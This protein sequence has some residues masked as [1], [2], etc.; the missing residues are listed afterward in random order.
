MKFLVLSSNK[1]LIESVKQ[2][3]KHIHAID[4]IATFL[5]TD[6][7]SNTYEI[8]SI[9]KDWIEE[10]FEN[11]IS[12]M[13][14]VVAF[15][16]LPISLLSDF[17]PVLNSPGSL[18]STL[19]LAFPE[20]YW[21]FVL[22]M[23][24]NEDHYEY[25]SQNLFNY[26]HVLFNGNHFNLQNMIENVLYGYTPLFDP[27]GFRY[28]IIKN[29]LEH[30]K[31]TGEG[32]LSERP[33]FYKREKKALVVDEEIPYSYLHAYIAYKTGHRT[34]AVSTKK[35]LDKIKTIHEQAKKEKFH[36]SFEDICLSF[37]DENVPPELEKREAPKKDKKSK[38]GYS[39]FKS[40]ANRV[41]VTIGEPPGVKQ[42]N[43]AYR[44]QLKAQGKLKFYKILYKPYS[45]I[46]NLIKAA[47]L[48]SRKKELRK[49]DYNSS[50]G[51]SAPGRMGMIAVLLINRGIKILTS[52]VSAIDAVHAATLA[53]QA[54]EILGGRT[55]TESIQAVSLKHQAEVL[56]ECIFYG[57]EHNFDI[58]S[59][60]EE[61][62]NELQIIG[63]WF[64]R[65][66]R[67]IMIYNSEL[68]I[69]NEV[70]RIFRK[71]SQFDEEQQ[72]LDKVRG[73]NRKI[74]RGKHKIWGTITWPFRC[75][76]EYLMGSLNRFLAA[77]VIWPSLFTLI[78]Y[79]L[80]P[81]N[82]KSFKDALMYS[83]NSFFA[84]Q[85]TPIDML[86]NYPLSSILS[87]TAIILGFFHLGIFIS[88][89]YTIVSRR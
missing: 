3:L 84:L 12:K 10:L 74:Y 16:D 83:I 11:K 57:V 5:V 14:E 41:F 33:F 76:F 51:H 27:T 45:G 22:P 34:L 87:I 68:N 24:T 62:E 20:I 75:Y 19:Y 42:A 31:E 21:I 25:F 35:L 79:L 80:M 54:Q 28:L 82:S 30:M 50:T 56:A 55:A 70:A 1:L 2:N 78:C 43:Q 23:S 39:F 15:I 26:F 13:R 58:K 4:D 46:F 48:G 40:I 6:Y 9:I 63:R 64:K 38:Y 89:L 86:T 44:R 17:N 32:L 61:I 18:A 36:I 29:T 66:K 59:R 71:Y 88:H 69:V 49:S 85:I 52:A 47:K 7:E 77:I 53:L 65:S 60:F 37:P 72:C 73:L 81:V 8:F 67:D